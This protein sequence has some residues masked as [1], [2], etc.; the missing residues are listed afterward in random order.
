VLQ[1]GLGALLKPKDKHRDGRRTETLQEGTA[2]TTE[3]KFRGGLCWDVW[4]KERS[5]RFYFE[6]GVG[7][8]ESIK[9]C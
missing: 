6:K 3:L 9:K 7:F 5:K 2:L 4:G 1:K 8:R